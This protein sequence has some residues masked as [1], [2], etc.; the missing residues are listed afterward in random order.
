MNDFLSRWSKYYAA[1]RARHPGPDK[2][3]TDLGPHTRPPYMWLG[4]LVRARVFL[5]AR[6][7]WHARGGGCGETCAGNVRQ[8]RRSVRSPGCW[9]PSPARSSRRRGTSSRNGVFVSGG[10]VGVPHSG[11]RETGETCA[12]ACACVCSGC[13]VCIRIPPSASIPTRG[14]VDYLSTGPAG[15]M[16]PKHYSNEWA[17]YSREDR[18][19]RF[20]ET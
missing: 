16:L 8:G 1:G 11:P 9:T 3:P 7:H 17:H 13:S 5:R 10:I 20:V 12:C 4:S 18:S 2:S 14:A 15:R 19:G 6:E